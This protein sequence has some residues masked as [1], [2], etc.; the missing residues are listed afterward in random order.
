VL[1]S[2]SN[3]DADL[4]IDDNPTNTDLKL[5][6]PAQR[7]ALALIDKHTKKIVAKYGF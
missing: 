1:E 5:R 2:E 7:A 3:Q 6:L 4:E